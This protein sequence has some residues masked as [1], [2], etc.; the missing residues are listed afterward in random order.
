MA[1]ILARIEI[2]A[3]VKVLIVWR[4]SNRILFMPLVINCG[5]SRIEESILFALGSGWARSSVLLRF[6]VLVNATALA[7]LVLV[8]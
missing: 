4:S 7:C 6:T 1:R 2:V 5:S 8:I 3:V